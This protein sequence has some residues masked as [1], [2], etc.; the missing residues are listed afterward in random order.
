MKK[1]VSYLYSLSIHTKLTLLIFS[2][3]IFI[4]ISTALV[5]LNISK[6]QTNKI[7]HELIYSNVETNQEQIV[8][9]LF[10][11]DYWKLYK[12]VK[13][14][15]NNTT[16]KYA[17]IIDD[18]K[19]VIVYSNTKEYKIGDKINIANVNYTKFPIINNDLQLG[20][21]ILLVEK[22]SISS[23]IKETFFN[24]FLFIILAGI[25]SFI[26]ANFF[27]RKLLNRFRILIHNTEAIAQRRWKE[28]KYPTNN[29][30]DEITELLDNSIVLMNEIKHSIEAEEKLK[31]F[32]H[33]ILKSLDSLVIICTNEFKSVY[34]NNHYL[35]SFILE[36]QN[37]HKDILKILI[38]EKE[39]S[40]SFKMKLQNHE[41]PIFLFV[42][43]H[44]IEENIILTF[45]DFTK[46]NQLEENEKIMHSLEALGEISSQFAHEIKNLIQ[47]LK[48]LIPKSSQP[49]IEDL[50]RIHETLS[51][52][53]K[54]ISDFLV[55]GK[56][57]NFHEY[58]TQNIKK[59]YDEVKKI[60]DISMQNKNICIKDK[61]DK[62]L[63]IFLEK[64]HIDLILINLITNA[65][66]ASYDYSDILISWKQLESN[67]TLL[68]I[69]N[70]GKTIPENIKEKIFKPFFT[71]KKDGSGL[72]LFSIYKIVYTAKG[73]IEVISK[74]EQT[75]FN[76]YIPNKP[77]I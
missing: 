36:N 6:I 27:T 23:M 48:L 22:E 37:I 45:T 29:E 12:F 17:G 65:I 1:L 10:A 62:N 14:L 69:Q 33:R 34:Q 71:T 73:R 68:K 15:S 19:N 25:F 76:I 46:L 13:A 42:N 67:M 77:L 20:T 74:N 64:K 3:V 16:I 11:N 38:K 24:N 40:N 70:R 59:V 61:I 28:I 43:I 49:D 60:L 47:P 2:V 4:S 26:I 63:T 53:G 39:K 30:K 75:T 50:P 9:A 58:K 35:S 8:S 7:L 51:K 54:Q 5:A 31:N 52:M 72:G 57:V 41:S 44:Y 66:E 18:K 55:L 56:P 21:L 32:Y